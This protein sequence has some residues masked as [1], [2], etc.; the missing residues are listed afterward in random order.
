MPPITTEQFLV[1]RVWIGDDTVI[2]DSDVQAYY[3]ELQSFDATV[4]A[5]LT[6]Q[7]SDLLRDPSQITVPGLSIS[8]GQN[9]TGMQ[10]LIKDF[11]SAGGTGLDDPDDDPFSGGVVVGRFV[12][13]IPR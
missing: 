2:S 6:K 7:L 13:V 11:N 10:Q 9:I 3:D 8:Q 4:R 12:R 5:I 1:L